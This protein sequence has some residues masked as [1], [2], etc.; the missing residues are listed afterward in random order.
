MEES[1]ALRVKGQVPVPFLIAG[2]TRQ[3]CHFSELQFHLPN[4]DL[5]HK[6]VMSNNWENVSGR[7]FKYKT[8]RE[9]ASNATGYFDYIQE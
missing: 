6:A 3:L 2:D 9:N 4:E 5:P 1:V 8:P 7:A